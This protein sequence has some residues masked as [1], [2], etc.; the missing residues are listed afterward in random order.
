[1][2]AS[3]LGLAI[4]AGAIVT[5]SVVGFGVAYT[6]YARELPTAEQFEELALTSFETTKI[7]D[8]TG[9]HLLYEVRNPQTGDRTIVPMH[10]IPMH[11]R[12]ATIALEDKTFY[13]NPAGINV[14]GIIR[15]FWNNLRGLPVQG[16]S[17]I[18]AQL[19]RNVAMSPEERYEVSYAR[20]IKEAI[21]CYELTRRYPGREGRDR[22][23]EW[24]LNTVFYGNHAYGVEAAA[25]A[26]FGKQAK[27][28]TLAEAAMLAPI[29]QSPVRNP[30][31]DP[32]AAKAR[33]IVALDTMVAEGYIT[34]AEAEEARHAELSQPSIPDRLQIEAPHFV[35][36]LLDVMT[37]RYGRRAVYGGGLR[38]IT[39]LD[40]DLQKQVENIVHRRVSRW[41]RGYNARNAAAVVIRPSTGEIL[42]MVGSADYFDQSIDGECNMAVEPRQPGSSIK[43]YTYAAA[44]E[45]GYGPG[46][47]V[48]D[49]RTTFHQAGHRPYTPTNA[50]GG[51]SGQ[52]SLRRALG[53]SLNVPAVVL[54]ERIGID[55]LVEMAHRLGITALRNPAQYVLP[56]TLGG[57]E[58]SLLDHTYAHSVFANDGVMAGVP[59]PPQRQEP[60]FRE[61]DPV[62]VLRATDVLGRVVDEYLGPTTRQLISPQVAYQ[63][64]SVLAD[65]EAR[66][67]A[68]G[69][70]NPL[71]L[72]R[73]A[74]VKTGTTTRF[75]DGWTMGYNPQVSVGVWAGNA[76]RSPMRGF[77]GYQSAGSIWRDIME[78]IF[79]T[80]PPV[81]FVEP[82]GMKWVEMD[83]VTGALPDDK[84][85]R[86]VVVE[87]LEPV[88][89]DKVRQEY[90]V[91]RSSGRLATEHCPPEGVELR[92]YE[93]YPTANG[94]FVR[95]TRGPQPPTSY[96]NQH[97]PATQT[98]GGW[99]TWPS[100]YETWGDAAQLLANRPVMGLQGFLG[101]TEE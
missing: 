88:S 87:G 26:Y 98:A 2:V 51:F 42:A 63:V 47:G 25:K 36:H 76:D 23:L 86:D 27:D 50:G 83:A 66:A 62:V 93:V 13:S 78:Y 29:P 89:K 99:P 16:G 19:A 60:G 75:C 10:D 17:S 69:Q 37:E 24:Y 65:N 95:S 34:E 61:L 3:L 59:V 67:P 64:S 94:S 5:V 11:M 45:Q 12:N 80:Q 100:L 71:R 7:Y 6:Y 91:C 55:S 30:I 31:H 46:T 18:A 33:Q 49:A 38:V 58:I 79:R 8:R 35:M 54:V 53:C 90:A 57:G 92:S 72:S 96:C 52:I 97:G 28:L 14:E 101:S 22:I 56:L 85:I 68:F 21:L 44:F 48:N 70:N 77:W 43:P 9:E 32:E 1:M 20:K 15:A 40:Y 82:P 4:M 84:K 73:P 39:T 81:D 41:P 74:A